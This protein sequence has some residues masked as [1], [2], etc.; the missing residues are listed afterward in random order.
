MIST[1]FNLLRP[2][3]RV[4]LNLS[5][6]QVSHPP[7]NPV[8]STFSIEFEP[9]HLPLSLLL[10][11]SKLCPSVTWTTVSA[12]LVVFH[13]CSPTIHSHSLHVSIIVVRSYIGFLNDRLSWIPTALRVKAQVVPMAYKN[14]HDWL[15]HIT[16]PLTFSLTL[17]APRSQKLLTASQRS[18][19]QALS[20]R[21]CTY[22]SL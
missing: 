10:F 20:Q 4:F 22:Y 11:L 14:L 12:C 1:L 8:N 17:S 5:F 15:P 2:K 21:H 6:P 16:P 13:L 18:Q 7:V 3:L 19:A 9:Y